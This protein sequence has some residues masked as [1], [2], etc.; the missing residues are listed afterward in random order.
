DRYSTIGKMMQ[1]D[2]SDIE[3]L[4]DSTNQEELSNDDNAED[5]N[6]VLQLSSITDILTV[7]LIAIV[8][9]RIAKKSNLF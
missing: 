2:Y 7:L 4:T 3:Y 6:S 1:I 9:L 8:G 5:D